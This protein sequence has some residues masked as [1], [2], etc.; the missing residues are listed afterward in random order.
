MGFQLYSGNTDEGLKG[1]KAHGWVAKICL[2]NSWPSKLEISV[3][4]MCKKIILVSEVKMKFSVEQKMLKYPKNF[5]RN[6]VSFINFHNYRVWSGENPHEYRESTLHPEKI[7]LWCG[8]SRKRIVGQFFHITITG[9]VY[10]DI[11]Q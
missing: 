4:E 5:P 9:D 7:G 10:Q 11:I 8:M 2:R 3:V 6:I 1:G